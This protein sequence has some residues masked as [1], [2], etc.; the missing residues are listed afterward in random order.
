[1]RL[2]CSHV[3]YTYVRVQCVNKLSAYCRAITLRRNF[4]M[5]FLMVGRV[6]RVEMFQFVAFEIPVIYYKFG[7]LRSILS[8]FC[9]IL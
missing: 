6:L 5:L 8:K 9:L 7:V 2:G 3:S 1:M 4:Y